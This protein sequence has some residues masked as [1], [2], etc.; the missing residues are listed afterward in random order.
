[1]DSIHLVAITVS[2]LNQDRHLCLPV[3]GLHGM[4]VLRAAVC[5]DSVEVGLVVI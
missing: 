4:L 1:M 5:D 2:I 3:G